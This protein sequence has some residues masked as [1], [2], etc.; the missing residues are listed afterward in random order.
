MNA[1]PSAEAPLRRKKV[2]VAVK[3]EPETTEKNRG[4]DDPM[5]EAG[6]Y[7]QNMFTRM[8]RGNRRE[9]AYAEWMLKDFR[10]H[11]SGEC[12]E[13]YEDLYFKALEDTREA[14]RAKRREW[15]ESIKR[16]TQQIQSGIGD[17][18]KAATQQ[19]NGVLDN[20]GKGTVRLSTDGMVP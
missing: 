17:A 2:R 5:K 1:G 18:A 6:A 12:S 10:K 9:R 20:A 8:A 14:G 13:F 19:L 7:L 16:A 11:V 15:V 3:K 4:Q